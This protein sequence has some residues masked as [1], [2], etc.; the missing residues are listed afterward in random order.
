MAMARRAGLKVRA[1][2][3]DWAGTIVDYGSLAPVKAFTEAFAERGINVPKSV[4]RA[5]M[6]MNKRDHIKA[7]F[8]DEGV[9]SAWKTETK[10]DWEDEDVQSIYDDF[11]P[12]QV[13]AAAERAT[14]IP[15]ALI[16]IASLR[17]AGIRIG[18]CSGYNA[19]ILRVVRASALKHG[20]VVDAAVSGNATGSNGRPKPW[21]SVA[22]AQKLDVYPF[23]TCVKVDDTPVGIL[24]GMNAG[25]WTVGVA[26]S[27]NGLGLDEA[28]ADALEKDEPAKYAAE[29]QTARDALK[30]AGANY[31][32]DSVR[33]L[34]AVVDD[35]SR[36]LSAGE[37]PF[38]ATASA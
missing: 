36:R 11:I 18:S 27:G 6:G 20:L 13:K 38:H 15:G 12:L 21:M 22:V 29:M 3:F 2:I 30:A 34:P 16:T 5:P 7:I 33:D 32:I 25:M 4:V 24:E 26:R 28:E 10:F 1:C 14:P 37:S 31:V 17:Q 8:K 19:E 9:A 23:I 35:I